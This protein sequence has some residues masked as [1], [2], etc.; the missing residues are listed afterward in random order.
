M[1]AEVNHRA[2]EPDVPVHLCRTIVLRCRLL[3][4]TDEIL[5]VGLRVEREKSFKRRGRETNDVLFEGGKDRSVGSYCRLD[6]PGT[7]VS[8]PGRDHWDICIQMRY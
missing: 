7:I 1:V 5:E 6:V 3:A 4:G 2:C 8:D